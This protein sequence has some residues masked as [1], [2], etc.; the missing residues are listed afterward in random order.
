MV[1]MA[2]NVLILLINLYINRYTFNCVVTPVEEDSNTCSVCFISHVRDGL[3]FRVFDSIHLNTRGGWAG[4]Y[5]RSS[6]LL[7]LSH[8][9][10]YHMIEFGSFT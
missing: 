2:H 8:S 5:A 10:D 3:F 4:G 7:S 1:T 9:H 6:C